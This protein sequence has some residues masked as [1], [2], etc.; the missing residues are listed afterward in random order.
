MIDVLIPDELCFDLSDT[1]VEHT[2]L[3]PYADP[4]EVTPAQEAQILNTEDK[5]MTGNVTVN[6]IP[7]SY[8][9]VSYNGFELTIS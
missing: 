5:V 1:P 8:G 4:Y 2:V 3:E 6:P 9:L 7:N